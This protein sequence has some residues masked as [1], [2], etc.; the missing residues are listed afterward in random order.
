L[1]FVSIVKI[2][3]EIFDSQS[4]LL[5]IVLPL[6]SYIT[7]SATASAANPDEQVKVSAI[8]LGQGQAV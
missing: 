7:G 1:C 4:D 3:R 8:H 6:P 5:F 2:Y